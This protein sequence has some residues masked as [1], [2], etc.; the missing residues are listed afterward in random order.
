MT[1]AV[2]FDGR[3]DWK[4]KDVWTIQG[5]DT[6]PKLWM[7]GA[8]GATHDVSSLWSDG[9]VVASDV[10]LH[11]FSHSVSLEEEVIRFLFK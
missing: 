3:T 10:E 6:A 8:S 7:S 2:V 4:P 1:T 9:F 11:L 5:L